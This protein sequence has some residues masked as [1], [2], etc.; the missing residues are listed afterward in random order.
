[1]K[2]ELLE[3]GRLRINR[4]SV[5]AIISGIIGGLVGVAILQI[6][7]SYIF[8][9]LNTVL[10]GTVF[11]FFC[12]YLIR[13]EFP[14][15]SLPMI[16]GAI[17]GGFLAG[18]GGLYLNFNFLFGLFFVLLFLLI[19]GGLATILEEKLEETET[20]FFVDW[21]LDIFGYNEGLC[22]FIL[23]TLVGGMCILGLLKLA[24]EMGLR[25][26]V[27]LGI[28]GFIPYLNIWVAYS[29]GSFIGSSLMDSAFIMRLFGPP[30]FAIPLFSFAGYFIGC[31]ISEGKKPK[32]RIKETP[33]G[34]LSMAED[35]TF[36]KQTSE[37]I[38]PI[39]F[40]EKA[41]IQDLLSALNNKNLLSVKLQS[42]GARAKGQDQLRAFEMIREM[43]EKETDIIEAYTANQQARL[44][45]ENLKEFNQYLQK[46]R[47]KAQL[48]E[49]KYKQTELEEKLKRMKLEEEKKRLELQQEIEKLK[50]V[51]EVTESRIER[52][53]KEQLEKIDFQEEIKK[54]KTMKLAD[55]MEYLHNRKKEIKKKY[56]PEEAEE[57]I[58]E[59]DRTMVEEGLKEE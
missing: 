52:I 34:G 51:R 30:Y 49:E 42:W 28:G 53:K 44:D 9:I 11:G 33:K 24:I 45:F 17:I 35:P 12:G 16:I 21:L 54:V 13:E 23:S 19:W 37:G 36:L 20:N 18:L 31:K 47:L 55:R 27:L 6:P 43:L 7:P 2:K 32:E 58:D 29:I 8:V 5:T 4:G 3:T 41:M 26:T 22:A 40:S 14:K 46:E 39:A 56:S 38:S 59:L 1:M 48:A 25:N 50:G 15:H 10:I 57:I